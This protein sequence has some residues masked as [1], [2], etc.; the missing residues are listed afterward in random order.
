M[1]IR[2]AWPEPGVLPAHG[3][4]VIDLNFLLFSFFL[5]EFLYFGY[6]EFS[7]S[8]MAMMMMLS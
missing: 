4:G 3:E 6:S 5:F 7:E 2:H 1:Q 8:A